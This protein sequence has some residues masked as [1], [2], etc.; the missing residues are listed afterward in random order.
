MELR[1]R[2]HGDFEDLPAI[3]VIESQI[4]LACWENW[5]SVRLFGIAREA[6]GDRP[7]P[8]A[9]APDWRAAGAHLRADA[10]CRDGR[11]SGCEAKAL[12]AMATR[13]AGL[14]STSPACLRGRM[15]A[16][17]TRVAL[18]P[19]SRLCRAKSGVRQRRWDPATSALFGTSSPREPR[20][21]LLGDVPTTQTP[22]P[23]AKA[24]QTRSRS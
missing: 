1:I 17:C 15:P 14:Q 19:S 24:P 2:G 13:G 7:K 10:E 8:P 9:K 12:N 5:Q 20:A 11:A 6:A 18:R 22:T 3:P 21:T 16:R 23:R 4:W